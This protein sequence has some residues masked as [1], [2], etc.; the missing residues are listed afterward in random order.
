MI[1]KVIC[2]NDLSVKIQLL[3]GCET[4]QI[5]ENLE[6]TEMKSCSISSEK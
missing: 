6:H 5:A 2:P 4:M 1:F 3:S